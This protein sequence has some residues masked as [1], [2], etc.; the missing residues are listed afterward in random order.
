[1]KHVQIEPIIIVQYPTYLRHLKVGDIVITAEL[2][3]IRAI[4]GR[5]GID[6]TEIND[7][8]PFIKHLGWGQQG[9]LKVVG[10]VNLTKKIPYRK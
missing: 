8:Y 7:Q 3:Q 9:I 4:H 10:G 5:E 2:H 6:C 1:M